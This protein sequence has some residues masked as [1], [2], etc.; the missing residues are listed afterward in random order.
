MRSEKRRKRSIKMKRKKTPGI[1]ILLIMCL[2]LISCTGGTPEP[3]VDTAEKAARLVQQDLS[4]E[5][6]YDLLKTSLRYKTKLYP[7]QNVEKGATGNWRVVSKEAGHTEDEE[8]PYQAL[9]FT[10]DP[11]SEYYYIVFFKKESVI[12]SDWF[13][14]SRGAVMIKVL[15]GT[16]IPNQ[17][18]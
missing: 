4:L 11:G 5:E 6:V 7:A 9:V 1:I 10:P 2:S 13:S 14:Y 15:E 16:L 17:S 12:G 18:E 3:P 8:A